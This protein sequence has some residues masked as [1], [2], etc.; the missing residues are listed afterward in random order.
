MKRIDS[1]KTHNNKYGYRGVWLDSKR[2]KY[3][4]TICGKNKRGR[5]LGRFNTPE[6]A[7][8]AYDEAAKEEYGENAFLNFPL[9]GEQRT[10]KSRL[11]EGFCPKE[12][13]LEKFGKVNSRGNKICTRCL[14]DAANRYYHKRKSK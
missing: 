3:V 14:A 10:I 5:H 2:Q 1:T 6:E 9:K 4:A 13:D 8:A 7:A 12:H 11:K